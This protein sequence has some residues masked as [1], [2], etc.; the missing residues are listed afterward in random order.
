M[1]WLSWAE[2][3]L[4]WVRPGDLIIVMGAGDISGLAYILVHNY[5]K[6]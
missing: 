5:N 4:D 3:A 2:M 1:R 6:K